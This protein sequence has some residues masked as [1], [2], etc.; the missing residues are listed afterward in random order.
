MSLVLNIRETRYID[1][2]NNMQMKFYKIYVHMIFE[3]FVSICNNYFEKVGTPGI[4]LQLI[5]EINI[6]IVVKIAG[7]S[8]T[9]K[10]L[11]RISNGF[12]VTRQAAKF[13]AYAD[14]R[15]CNYSQLS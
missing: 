9:I 14:R 10:Q 11:L 12:V 2:F 1:H 7:Q 6:V 8:T 15:T 13:S 5:I 3:D 4:M